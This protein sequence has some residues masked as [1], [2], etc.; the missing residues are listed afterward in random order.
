MRT[1]NVTSPP[2]N[3]DTLRDASSSSGISHKPTPEAELSRLSNALLTAEHALLLENK[4]PR[5]EGW[6][7][8]CLTFLCC[9]SCVDAYDAKKSEERIGV[10][11]KQRDEAGD[12][13]SA[14][15]QLH[16]AALKEKNKSDVRGDARY[17]TTIP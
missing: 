15:Y 10:L 9:D 8:I 11:E 17:G 12:K 5:R 14:F 16:K 1:A 6:K 4:T 7:R 13:F 3:Y 2:V